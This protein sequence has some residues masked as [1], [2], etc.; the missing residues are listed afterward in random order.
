MT[1][2]LAFSA[3][4]LGTAKKNRDGKIHHLLSMY[5]NLVL[6]PPNKGMCFIWRTLWW[7]GF[8]RSFRR[9]PIETL[10]STHSMRRRHACA[11]GKCGHLSGL[12]PYV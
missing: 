6:G 10:T 1:L 4:S 11:A 9:S 8:F 7:K 12:R 5:R 3:S 2:R